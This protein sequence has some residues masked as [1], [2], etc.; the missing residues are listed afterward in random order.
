MKPLCK[1]ARGGFDVHR[2][3]RCA[4]AARRAGARASAGRTTGRELLSFRISWTA[5]PT[6]CAVAGL[7]R[8]HCRELAQRRWSPAELRI[9]RSRPI[10]TVRLATTC[11]LWTRRCHDFPG[12]LPSEEFGDG[13]ADAIRTQ[14]S[15]GWEFPH[16]FQSIQCTVRDSSQTTGFGSTGET[17]VHGVA[18][19]PTGAL[20]SLSAVAAVHSSSCFDEHNAYA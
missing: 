3:P 18:P 8:V 2:V 11:N 10:V 19:A 4:R 7:L 15:A 12:R 6:A 20:P 17:V 13:P 1:W 14:T 9:P 16:F 5:Q